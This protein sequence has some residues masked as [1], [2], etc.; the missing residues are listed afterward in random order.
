MEWKTIDSAPIGKEMF[1]VKA[2]G[3]SLM[4]KTYTSDPYCVWQQKQGKFERWPHACF[5]P[6]HWAQL[7]DSP[8]DV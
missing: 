5:L 8:K 4:G 1:V 2:F 6:T 3:V 7:P